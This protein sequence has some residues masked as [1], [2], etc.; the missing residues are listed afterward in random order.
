MLA[1]ARV[2]RWSDESSV[3]R[4]FG[5]SAPLERGR[6]TGI[7]LD[8]SYSGRSIASHCYTEFQDWGIKDFS[9]VCPDYV[10]ALPQSATIKLF[11]SKCYKKRVKILPSRIQC[12]T[13]FPM[14]AKFLRS[15]RIFANISFQWS[16]PRRNF[17]WFFAETLVKYFMII[18]FLCVTENWAEKNAQKKS[19]TSF[20]TFQM[21]W[22]FSNVFSP[23]IYFAFN[24]K[25]NWKFCS[26]RKNST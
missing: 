1:S 5:V 15:A 17:S 22:N 14:K 21:Q 19:S 18:T 25:K 16:R 7:P 26:F 4:L 3:Q 20:N 2:N 24:C 6:D 12:F 8:T 13:K 10:N 11:T 23:R 9:G